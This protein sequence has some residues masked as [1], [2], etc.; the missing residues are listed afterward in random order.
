MTFVA[1]ATTGRSARFKCSP[2]GRTQPLASNGATPPLQV[3]SCTLR[4]GWLLL[5]KTTKADPSPST[6][7]SV[8][9]DY[10]GDANYQSSAATIGGTVK[11]S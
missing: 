7:W 9:A 2:G 5:K 11:S 10:T 3:A 4:S 8:S 6:S 1:T